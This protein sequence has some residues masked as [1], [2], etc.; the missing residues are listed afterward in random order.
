MSSAAVDAFMANVR[1]RNPE[2]QEFLQAVREVVE[3]TMPVI[4]RH[5]EYRAAESRATSN[6]LW[7]VPCD[8]A[9]PSVTQN[10]ING[11]DAA[12]LTRN[13]CYCICEYV[14][15]ANN[16]GFLKVADAMIDMGIV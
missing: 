9:L 12:N 1:A 14:V 8:I 10:E 16:A 5:P 15:G 3:S 13:G 11:E 4:E 6:P 7:A 2:Q